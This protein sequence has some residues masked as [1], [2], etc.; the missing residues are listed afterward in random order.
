[1]LHEKVGE[2]N[3]CAFIMGETYNRLA[4]DSANG[5]ADIADPFWK[6]FN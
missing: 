1:M 3:V 4:W 2:S 6:T 5:V